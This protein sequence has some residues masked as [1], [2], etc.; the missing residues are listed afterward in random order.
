MEKNILNGW[1]MHDK[2]AA[3]IQENR[4]VHDGLLSL[5]PVIE[6][7]ARMWVDCIRAGGKVM[8]AGNGGSAAD[9]QHLA[10]ELVNRF[11]RERAPMAGLAL[12][13]DTSILTAIGNDYG[14]EEVFAKQVSALGRKGDVLVGL[15]TSGSSPNV[16]RAVVAAKALGMATISLTGTLG[17]LKDM[18]DCAIC[19]PS[20]STPRIQEA[21]ILIGHILCELVEEALA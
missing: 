16:I 3:I 8:F 4:E 5:A 11:R 1:D 14:F 18:A 9:A 2:I 12:T 13:T 20:D 15:S 10:A 6:Q 7:A 21:H 17:R 19:V